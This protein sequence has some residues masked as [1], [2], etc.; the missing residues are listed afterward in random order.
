MP[1]DHWEARE[2]RIY[3]HVDRQADYYDKDY[4]RSYLEQKYDE[5]EF[6]LHFPST[7]QLPHSEIV[8]YFLRLN[9]V[10]EMVHCEDLSVRLIA[11]DEQGRTIDLSFEITQGRL[12]V[13][14]HPLNEPNVKIELPLAILEEIISNN[15]SWD[16]A[17]IGY[18]CRFDRNPDV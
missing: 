15:I 14:D 7:R 10:P 13:L 3:R 6:L 12:Q 2:N 4:K 8:R 16:E 17:H 1:G 5:N 9:D 11:S 18:W